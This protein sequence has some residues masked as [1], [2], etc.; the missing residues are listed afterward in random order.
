[1]ENKMKVSR[2]VLIVLGFSL[3]LFATH[4]PATAQA[5]ATQAQAANA[6]QAQALK[7]TTSHIQTVW[8]ILM[9]NHNWSQIL[10]SKNA[11]YINNTLL[12]MA[13]HAEQFFNPPGIHPSLPNYLWLEAGTNFGIL[14]DNPPS[15]DHQSTTQHLVA[16]LNNAGIT[17][18]AYEENIN[19]TV[20]PLTDSYPYAVRHDPFVYFDDDTDNLNPNSAYCISHVRPYTEL[21]SDLM[22]NSVASYNFITPNVCDDMHDKCKGNP[23]GI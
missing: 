12:P 14:D 23:L 11:P 20:F 13:S 9:E 5:T 21:A 6:T 7:V 1:M 4:V 16:L 3:L 22:A 8:I 10:G 19:G 17:W 2:L 15:I 18:K